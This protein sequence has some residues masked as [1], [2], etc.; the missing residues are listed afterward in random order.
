MDELY[1]IGPDGSR[2][3]PAT[4]DDLRKWAAEGRVLRTTLIE[5]SPGM[6]VAATEIQGLFPAEHAAAPSL[7]SQQPPAGAYYNR[8][9]RYDKVENHL[10]KSI[11]AT[12]F[13]CLPLGIAAI[14]KAASVDG[15]VRS[16]N[17]AEARQ[18]AEKANNWSNWAIGLGLVI[19]LAYVGVMVAAAVLDK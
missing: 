2:Y 12:V 16:G 18:A 3:G 6:Q 17:H 8:E 11:L 4:L 9:V 14:I 19:N 1:V 13:C 15:L 10:I 7:G 5:K